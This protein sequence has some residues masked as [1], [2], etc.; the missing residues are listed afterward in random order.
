MKGGRGTG[1]ARRAGGGL[2]EERAGE[3]DLEFIAHS[4]VGENNSKNI[5]FVKKMP[6]YSEIETESASERARKMRKTKR[7]RLTKAHTSF[8]GWRRAGAELMIKETPNSHAHKKINHQH[9]RGR[10]EAGRCAPVGKFT[11]LFVCSYEKEWGRDGLGRA[12]GLVGEA[13]KE[14]HQ[15]RRQSE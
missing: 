6:R 3:V 13:K 11:F 14:Q 7:F 4:M 1:G 9:H 10:E 5:I 2:G 12:G 15:T 8:F